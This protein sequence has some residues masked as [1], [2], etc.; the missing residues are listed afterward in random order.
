[1][2]RIGITEFLSWAY[3][4]ELPKAE[5]RAA[6]V[7][8]GR[9]AG[10]AGGWDGVSRQGAE[11]ALAVSDGRPNAYGVLPLA[12]FDGPQP[13]SGYPDEMR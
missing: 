6:A 7:L 4:E 9:P 5:R 10:A 3:L 8:A 12:G 2:K 11:M 1:M 13:H